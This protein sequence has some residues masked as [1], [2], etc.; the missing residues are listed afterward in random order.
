VEAV[1]AL[2]GP[3]VALAELVTRLGQRVDAG[4]G[5][6]HLFPTRAALAARASG[7]IA[8][9]ARG[10][11]D[12]DAPLEELVAALRALPGVDARRA[13]AVALHAVG[14]VSGPRDRTSTRRAQPPR[15]RWKSAIASPL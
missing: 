6:T 4:D 3:R 12:F 14:I 15:K 5:L 8:A 10:A 2:A 1:R 9:L 7:A 11:V 13:E